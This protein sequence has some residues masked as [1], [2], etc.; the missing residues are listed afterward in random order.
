MLD[1]EK[2]RIGFAMGFKSK[3]MVSRA[4]RSMN[5][6]TELKEVI[7]KIPSCKSIKLTQNELNDTL[8]KFRRGK[9]NILI[10]TNVVE[11]GLDVSSCNQVICL[12]ELL[13]VK[14]FIQM[15]GRA[16]RTNS[17]FVF[18]CAEEEESSMSESKD[19]FGRVIEIMKNITQIRNLV[20]DSLLIQQSIEQAQGTFFDI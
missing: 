17:K 4:Y 15:K 13:T 2:F 9:L 14:A 3:N 10:A 11:E 7:S 12:N 6:K 16:R 8:D 19:Q 1:K 20:P 18:I 5:T